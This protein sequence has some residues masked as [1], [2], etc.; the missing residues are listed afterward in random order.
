MTLVCLT[1][2]LHTGLVWMH[3]LRILLGLWAII[4][5]G[6]HHHLLVRMEDLQ[7]PYIT[8]QSK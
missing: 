6:R 7:L 4:L 2:A 3:D 8:Y 5:E 1:T